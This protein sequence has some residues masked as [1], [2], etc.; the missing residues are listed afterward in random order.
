M[1]I[2]LPVLAFL[3]IPYPAANA[4]AST[5]THAQ[6]NT[7]RQGAFIG[8]PT[9]GPN[10]PEVHVGNNIE[11]FRS[12]AEVSADGDGIVHT[13]HTGGLSRSSPW[14]WSWSTSCSGGG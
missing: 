4:S 12:I 3:L 10:G 8:V 5:P 7:H 11:F 2:G 9:A 6:R 1:F 14:R 13:V